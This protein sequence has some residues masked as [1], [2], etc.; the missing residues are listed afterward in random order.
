M[1]FEANKLFLL[2]NTSLVKYLYL[3]K[4]LGKIKL[5]GLEGLSLYD[6]LELYVTGIAKGALGQ[7][8]VLLLIV[9]LWHC[10]RFCYL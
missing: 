1:S 10:F 9:F 8:Q 5:P 7:E 4:L 2:K 6:L 3:V